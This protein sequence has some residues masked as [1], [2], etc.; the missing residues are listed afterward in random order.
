MLDPIG[1]MLP[2]DE[3]QRRWY[4]QAARGISACSASIGGASAPCRDGA[5]AHTASRALG[6]RVA[7]TA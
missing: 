7:K 2:E 4:L 5:P 3:S 6:L 1:E